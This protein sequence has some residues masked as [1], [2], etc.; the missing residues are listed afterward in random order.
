[1]KSIKRLR[2]CA[3]GNYIYT[4]PETD[5]EESAGGFTQ[6]LMLEM[7]LLKFLF[8]SLQLPAAPSKSAA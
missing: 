6:T 7:F 4:C 5:I 3:F 2:L 1:M 8:R